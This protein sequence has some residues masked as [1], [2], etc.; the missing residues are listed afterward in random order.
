MK[1]LLLNE[2]NNTSFSLLNIFKD[3]YV[4]IF[5]YSTVERNMYIPGTF[6]K[7]QAPSSKPA[8]GNAERR[9]CWRRIWELSPACFKQRPRIAKS[10]LASRRTEQRRSYTQKGKEFLV[11]TGRVSSCS[12]SMQKC[13]LIEV[14]RP[15]R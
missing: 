9:C 10:R 1:S 2:Q 11:K 6:M 5:L 13:I 15:H 7:F 12:C 8:S 4:N 3:L 14:T